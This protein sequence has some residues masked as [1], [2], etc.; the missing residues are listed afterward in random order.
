MVPRHSQISDKIHMQ[1]ILDVARIFKLVRR[2]VITPTAE[3]SGYTPLT[4]HESLPEIW[5]STVLQIPSREFLRICGKITKK[6]HE[7]PAIYGYL[8]IFILCIDDFPMEEPWKFTE[9]GHPLLDFDRM[10]WVSLERHLCRSTSPWEVPKKRRNL[11][12]KHE[13]IWKYMLWCVL[14]QQ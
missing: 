6:I 12:K 11:G 1:I 5:T 2:W 4:N 10:L 7:T 3:A 8:S 9:N 13:N 14:T